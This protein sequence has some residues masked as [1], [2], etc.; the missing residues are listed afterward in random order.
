MLSTAGTSYLHDSRISLLHVV[1]VLSYMVPVQL[2]L[3][4][5]CPLAHGW[6]VDVLLVLPSAVSFKTY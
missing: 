1:N 3:H 2:H 4:L 6:C 5:A